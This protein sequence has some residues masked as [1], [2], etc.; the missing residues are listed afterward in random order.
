VLNGRWPHS[1]GLHAESS[2]DSALVGRVEQAA[3][4]IAIACVCSND[5]I[6]YFGFV[7]DIA[8]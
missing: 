7:Y 2:A 5:S 4:Y 6:A 3:R 8:T 1:W